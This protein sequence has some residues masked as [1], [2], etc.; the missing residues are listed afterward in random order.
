[1]TTEERVS[2]LESAYE[3]LAT[4]ADIAAAKGDLESNIATVKGDLESNIATVKGDLE[5]NIATAKSDL[6]SNIATVKADLERAISDLR[7]DFRKAHI[8]LVM[9]MTGTLL[10]GMGVAAA[11]AKLVSG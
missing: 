1:M 7:D 2:R 5:S 4:K 11:V 10:V 6:E 9:W 8:Q 3:H